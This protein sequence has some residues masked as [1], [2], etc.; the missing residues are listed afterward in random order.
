MSEAAI[1]AC[2]APSLTAEDIPNL[3]RLGDVYAINRALRRWK[4]QSVLPK[5]AFFLDDIEHFKDEMPLIKR[6]EIEKIIREGKAKDWEG[7][8]TL[9]LIKFDMTASPKLNP[10]DKPVLTS[11][12]LSTL[13]AWQMLVRE[14]YKRIYMA[15]CECRVGEQVYFCDWQGSDVEIERR[16]KRY[17]QVCNFLFRWTDMAKP[18]GVETINLSPTSRLKRFMRT[19]TVEEAVKQV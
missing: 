8:P 2:P 19:M 10:F 15:G 18:L 3:H 7:I 9:R 6:P 5:A 13:V 1:I 17:K 12:M 16:R 14:G 11:P 4:G